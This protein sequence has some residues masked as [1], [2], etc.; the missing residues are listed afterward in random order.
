MITLN[1]KIYDGLLDAIRQ[2]NLEVNYSTAKARVKRGWSPE[3]ALG[4][5]PRSLGQ[6]T[7]VTVSGTEYPS[8]AEASRQLNLD[9]RIVRNRLGRKWSPEEAL[10]LGDRH[11]GKQATITVSGKV[12]RSIRAAYKVIKPEVSLSTVVARLATGEWTASQAFGLEYRAT[13]SKT[14]RSIEVAGTTYSSIKKAHDTLESGIPLATVRNRL[15]SGWT[16]DEAFGLSSKEDKRSHG[17]GV[18]VSGVHY[19]SVDAAFLALKPPVARITIYKRL[20]R[21]MAPELAFTKH[22]GVE[23]SEFYVGKRRYPSFEAAY[24]DLSP[25]VLRGTVAERLRSG[26]WTPEE[27]FEIVPRVKSRQVGKSITVAGVEY[28]NAQEAYESIGCD[29]HITTVRYR[30]RHGWTPEQAFGLEPR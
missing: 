14:T 4:L 22:G 24:E 3:E 5:T 19:P 30:L 20:N 27:A 17:D 21:G 6:R 25:S 13:H 15:R 9:P 7:P 2:L 28:A 1:G 8:V 11:S 10:E 12:Y 16:P 29:F 26:D 18:T 23:E